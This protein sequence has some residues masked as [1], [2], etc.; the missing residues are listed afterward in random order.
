MATLILTFF[1]L[2]RQEAKLWVL[3]RSVF[4]E[5]IYGRCM[6]RIYNFRENKVDILP[7]EIQ[8]QKVV[9]GEVIHECSEGGDEVSVDVKGNTVA[10]S[11]QDT[12]V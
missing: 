6:K 3:L 12:N 7:N 9:Q 1:A 5:G 2:K 10:Q 8:L 11:Q 4:A